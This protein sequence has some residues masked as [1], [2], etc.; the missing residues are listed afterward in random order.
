MDD[1][2]GE[3]AEVRAA[4]AE[5]QAIATAKLTERVDELTEK[6]RAAEVDKLELSLQ[7]ES[8][9]ALAESKSSQLSMVSAERLR[10]HDRV[11]ELQ[12]N[13]RVF[14]RVRP[15]LNAGKRVVKKSR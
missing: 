8:V 7:L 15:S 10:L 12:G 1:L 4:A 3:I 2:K 11:M 5:A 14:V 6:L 9:T 13:I